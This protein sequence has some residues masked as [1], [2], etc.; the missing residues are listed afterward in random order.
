MRVLPLYLLS[1]LL[2]RFDAWC[3]NGLGRDASGR[4]RNLSTS[5]QDSR[6]RSEEHHD[7]DAWH[8]PL[9]A[10]KQS[11][12][13]SVDQSCRSIIVYGL[14]AY[15]SSVMRWWPLTHSL[16]HSLPAYGRFIDSSLYHSLE[17]RC[18]LQVKLIPRLGTLCLTLAPV[19]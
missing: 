7:D 15:L 11:V 13:Q 10:C 14:Y 6:N 4:V 9:P 3:A 19:V 5:S 18:L 16:T 2:P 12:S 8:F 1:G 17:R